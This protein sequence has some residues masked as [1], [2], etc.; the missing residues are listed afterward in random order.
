MQNIK[1]Y[2]S[3]LSKRDKFLLFFS[4]CLLFFVFFKFI[5]FDSLNKENAKLVN[6][7]TLIGQ[8][9]KIIST[10]DGNEAI[11]LNTS[12]QTSNQLINNFLKQNSSSG[13]LKQIRTTN[14]GSKRYE[15]EE[16]SFT[17]LI[18]LLSVLEK[19]NM[20]YQNLQIKK[21]KKT[22]MIDAVIIIK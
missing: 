3:Q 9:E 16:I 17:N 18:K 2:I 13:A 11:T 7:A 1:D 21:T 4:V 6:R 5:L 20:S 12:S 15:L 14:D 22:G 8:Q 10:L 19:S